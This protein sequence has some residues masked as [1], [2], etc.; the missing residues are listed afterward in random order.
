MREMSLRE[1]QA[2]L[3][4]Q[5]LG[6]DAQ[7]S[8]VFTDSRAPQAGGLFVALAG[9][10]FDGHDYLP[11][12]AAAGA[13]AAL[14]SRPLDLSLPQLL[15]EDTQSGL[16]RLGAFNRSLYQGPLVAITG[17]AGKTTAKNLIHAVL[18]QRGETLATQGNLNNEIGVPLTLLRLAPEHQ[19]AVVEMGAARRGDI[20]WLCELG[21]PTVSVLLN[22]NPAHLEGF[23]SLEGVAA[24]KG[25]IFDGLGA[26]DV[27]VINADQPWAGQWRERA[28][29]ARVI[30]FSLEKP[31]SV[32]ARGV[33][34]G[35]LAGCSFTAVTG[36]GEFPV[37]LQLAG[38]HNVANALAAIAVGIAC[39]LEAAEIAAGL[40]SVAPAAGRL[41]TVRSAAGVTLIDDCYNANPASVHAAIDLLAAAEGRR[42][43]VMGAMRELGETSAEMHREL[44][45]YA[46]AAGLEQFWGVGEELREAVA[47][48]GSGGRWFA[49]CADA[50]DAARE[51]FAQGDVV[52][53]KGSRGA[54]MER[55]LQALVPAGNG[56]VH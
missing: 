3:A 18:A 55:V 34:A 27:A 51:V 41:S 42:T 19:F 47:A 52:L 4:A 54:R 45:E 48:F 44:G 14:V 56:E 13:A 43:L 1:L 36:A 25:E 31:A 9:E 22:A 50:A 30:D 53:I 7:F 40:A 21:R 8:A 24:T 38:R 33:K 15:V 2:P 28:G 20:A 49:D 17:S 11:A 6:D 26:G 32:C 10:N 12:V 29:A 37:Q 5:L 23:G 16:G 46:R 35:G 39:G